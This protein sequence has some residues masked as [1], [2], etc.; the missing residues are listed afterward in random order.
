[1]VGALKQ[2]AREVGHRDPQ[3][4]DRAAEGGH[5]AR[6]QRRRPDQPDPH[7][8]DAD[9]HRAG[10]GLA[11][12]QRVERLDAHPRDQQAE[13]DERRQPGELRPHHA[14]ELAERPDDV[15]LDVLGG[16]EAQQ[17]AHERGRRVAEEHAEDQQRQRRHPLRD[18]EHDEQHRRGAGDACEDVPHR[19]PG[20]EERTRAATAEDDE[21]DS[22]A[23]AR[24]D[25]Q[26]KRARQRVA[27]QRL[28]L[29]PA[30]RQRGAREQRGGRLR[31]AQRHD[32]ALPGR[33]LRA[34]SQEDGG[35]LAQ[36]DRHRAGGD[37]GEKDDEEAEA[38]GAE[39]GP[40]RELH[41]APHCA[42]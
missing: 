20:A 22:Q 40:A 16:A 25:P 7:P 14:A 2:R 23:G 8:L 13:A 4:A 3:K 31:Q 1:M 5:R 32:D 35:D 18:E 30:D 10:V 27:E 9:A 36:R 21:G 11:E 24:A 19:G 6:Q 42:R 34:A 17:D 29:Q 33:V 12:E 41:E 39:G 37:V 15:D 26:H 28:H 38:Q